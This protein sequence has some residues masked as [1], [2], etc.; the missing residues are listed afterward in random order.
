MAVD[1]YVRYEGGLHCASRH[2]PSGAVLATD[3]PADNHGRGEAFSPTDLTATSLGT[4]MLTT[5]G[6][7]ANKRSW[8]IAGLDAHVIKEMTSSPPR[9]IERLRVTIDA[10]AAL[11]SKLTAEARAELEEAAHTCP[12]RLSLHPQLEVVVG[13]RWG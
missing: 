1:I 2:A 10:P 13:F 6:I 4:C 5:M 8:N 3:A 11:A 9:K 12:V 7:L